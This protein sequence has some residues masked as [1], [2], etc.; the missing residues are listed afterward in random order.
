MT[1]KL[2]GNDNARKF[3][4]SKGWSG[5]NGAK[6]CK[7]TALLMPVLCV[8]VVYHL[9]TSYLKQIE[10]KYT[11]RAANLYKVHLAKLVATEGHKHKVLSPEHKVH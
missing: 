5:G 6:V 2:G 4:A 10:A 1:M 3:F 9:N 11:S 7:S 8:C